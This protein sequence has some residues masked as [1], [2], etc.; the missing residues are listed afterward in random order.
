MIELAKRYSKAAHP[1][2]AFETMSCEGIS[3]ESGCFD[4]VFMRFFVPIL[5]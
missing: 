3:C 5:E 1:D 2:M 4:C